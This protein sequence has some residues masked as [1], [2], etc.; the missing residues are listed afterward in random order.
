LTT[1]AIGRLRPLAVSKAARMP[2]AVAR[3]PRRAG[4]HAT[5]VALRG[6]ASW[7]TTMPVGGWG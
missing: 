6:V 4:M 3:R 1:S 2:L 7:E 5:T